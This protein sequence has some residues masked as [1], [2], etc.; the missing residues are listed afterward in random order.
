MILRS[1]CM[2]TRSTDS[3]EAGAPTASPSAARNAARN[4]AAVRPSACITSS[5]RSTMPARACGAGRRRG[6]LTERH[7]RGIVQHAQL[8]LLGDRLLLGRIGFRSIGIA[9]LLELGIA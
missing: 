8:D 4:A 1:E 5:R 9:Q 7:K 3:A 6:E 2:E